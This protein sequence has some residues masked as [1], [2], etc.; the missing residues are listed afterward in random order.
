MAIE[1]ATAPTRGPLCGIILTRMNHMKYK[2]EILVLLFAFT[3][4]IAFG[5]SSSEKITIGTVDNIHSKILNENREIWIYVPHSRDKDIYGIGHYPVIYLLDGDSHFSSLSGMVDKLGNTICPEMIVVAILNTDRNRD[6]TPTHTDESE[7]GQNT[8]GGEKFTEFLDK[9]L[10]P[11]IDSLYPTAPYRMLI[12]HSFGGLMVVNTLLNHTNL[13]NAYVAIDP[14]L[15]WD[16]WTLLQHPENTIAL[17]KYNGKSFYLAIAN[18][19]KPG[20]DT[21]KVRTDTVK[22]KQIRSILKFSDYLKRYDKNGL[23]WNY[24]Y[25]PEYGHNSVPF[26]AEYDA[27]INI[28]DYYKLP[29]GDWIFEDST[30]NALDIIKSHFVDIS[31]QMGY[32]VHPPESY[33]NELAYYF[34]RQKDLDK[35]YAYFK[36]NLDNYPQSFN[37]VESLGEFY[38]IKKDKQKAIE[39]YTKSLTIKEYPETRK[40]LEK[41]IRENKD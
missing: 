23:K 27:L 31:K 29:N 14:S 20:M 28:F 18:T 8:G 32:V 16:N 25:Y 15:W 10:I 4:N 13:F 41:L 1:S 39:Y 37:A 24:K 30:V 35:A 36:L 33:I 22:T 11:H 40:Q 34:M 6:L 9:E 21:S 7:F 2:T 3:L 38:E 19:M 17:K 26:I 5:Q 12:G